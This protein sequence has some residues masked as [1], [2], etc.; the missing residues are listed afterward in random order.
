MD[1]PNQLCA[2]YRC[3]ARFSPRHVTR[4]SS[5]G[6]HYD[7]SRRITTHSDASRRIQTHPN[8]KVDES[9]TEQWAKVVAW[10]G[11]SPSEVLVGCPHRKSSSEVQVPA[12]SSEAPCSRGRQ[13]MRQGALTRQTSPDRRD[14]LLAVPNRA[15]ELREIKSFF[16]FSPSC[17]PHCPHRCLT[18]H[19]VIHRLRHVHAIK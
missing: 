13:R 17:R 9:A 7:A 18:A 12:K 3:Q 10:S 11:R 4:A 14:C 15:W 1:G 16:L 5:E 2:T 19:V 8:L 6:T